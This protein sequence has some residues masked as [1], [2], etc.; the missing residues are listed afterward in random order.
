M[1][2]TLAGTIFSVIFIAGCNWNQSPEELQRLVK[3]EPAFRQMI[4]QRDQAHT[5]ISRIK[6]DLL[7]RKQVLDATVEKLR[8][9][10]DTYAKAQNLK[11]EQYRATVDANRA[12][13]KSE[14]DVSQTRIES[15]QVELDGYLKTL[16]DVEKVLGEA[17]GITLSSQE[18]KK[19]Q[20]RILMLNEKIRPLK[21]DIQDLKLQIR[22][23]KQK[24]GYLT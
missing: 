7:K 15:K 2:K 6:D 3:E 17:K 16:V 20:E 10:Y 1:S 11:V 24:I 5:Q 13:L 4:A 18:K 8:S 22:L 23:K 14:I 21:D 19:W 9:Q 12:R